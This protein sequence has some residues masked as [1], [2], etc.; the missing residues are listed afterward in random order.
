MAL[1]VNGKAGL[2]NTGT[3]IAIFCAGELRPAAIGTGE[4]S[5][6]FG[7][8]AG[9]ERPGDF[10]TVEF[11]CAGVVVGTWATCCTPAAASSPSSDVALVLPPDE[12][13]VGVVVGAE[14]LGVIAG[15]W[16]A[17]CLAAYGQ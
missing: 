16:I 10:S 8:A 7:G 9:V 3:V 6:F 17:A 14:A 13:F 15:G 1:G 4:I 2:F 11:I 5:I 12:G